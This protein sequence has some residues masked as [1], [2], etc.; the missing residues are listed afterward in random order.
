MVAG[1]SG[2]AP[3]RRFEYIA[4]DL[5]CI[6]VLKILGP[7]KKKQRPQRN[8]G[9]EDRDELRSHRLSDCDKEI[10]PIA[11]IASKIPPSAWVE[12]AKS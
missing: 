12:E 6:I 5:A 9:P 11:A 8:E 1:A 10:L 3:G 4:L 7:G 2:D